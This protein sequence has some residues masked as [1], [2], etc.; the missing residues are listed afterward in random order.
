MSRLFYF[1]IIFV[2]CSGCATATTFHVDIDSINSGSWENKRNIFLDSAM[3]NVE[4]NDLQFKEYISYIKRALISRGFT[5]VD[6]FQQADMYILV[7]YGVSDPQEYS[8]TY[9]VPTWGQTGYS[10][11]K[12]S[13]NASSAGYGQINYQ[14]ATTYQPSYGIIGSTT[15]QTSSVIYVNYLILAGFDATMM[16]QNPNK[17]IPKSWKTNIFSTSENGDLRYAFPILVAAAQPYIGE[18]TGHRIT[19]ELQE[20]DKR[21]LEIMSGAREININGVKPRQE[22]K[23]SEE[24]AILTEDSEVVRWLSELYNKEIRALTDKEKKDGYKFI[25]DD[26]AKKFDMIVRSIIAANAAVVRSEEDFVNLIRGTAKVVY[27]NMSKQRKES[28]TQI[29]P[30]VSPE[31]QSIMRGRTSEIG[32]KE[33]FSRISPEMWAEVEKLS[34]KEGFKKPW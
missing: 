27:D 13:G 11:A 21:I 30:E 33:P 2:F 8:Y 3:E 15:Q 32:R 4:N 7:K 19:V 18:N 6:T 9:S 29:S 1:V 28:S 23:E 20:N 34:G 14:E 24:E 16:K 12:T 22:S 31:V 17:S 25:D 5:V 10:S 26:E